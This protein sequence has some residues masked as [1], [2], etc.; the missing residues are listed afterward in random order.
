MSVPKE[1]VLGHERSPSGNRR[2]SRH[3]HRPPAVGKSIRFQSWNDRAPIADRRAA[4]GRHRR[5]I[6]AMG[7]DFHTY[8][9]LSMGIDG[10][11]AVVFGWKRGR[12]IGGR[13]TGDFRRLSFRPNPLVP[14][15]TTNRAEF[16]FS[17]LHLVKNPDIPACSVPCLRRLSLLFILLNQLVDSLAE[18]PSPWHV[19]CSSP[20]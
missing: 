6:G 5:R 19:R 8:Q 11:S 10:Y 13:F 1:T 14:P 9:R 12:R 17:G 18:I 2:A 16:P 15:C 20:F 3:L 7:R 4:M